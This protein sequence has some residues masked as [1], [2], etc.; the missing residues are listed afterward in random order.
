M[1]IWQS[2]QIN[3]LKD[4]VSLNHT[5]K[6]QTPP[7]RLYLLIS[8]KW[9]KIKQIL[10]MSKVFVKNQCALQ[11]PPPNQ[12]LCLKEI[13]DLQLIRSKMVVKYLICE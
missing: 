3:I 9:I 5:F 11:T 8:L 12:P 13:S 6:Q 1:C 4:V 10:Q 7:K 2:V